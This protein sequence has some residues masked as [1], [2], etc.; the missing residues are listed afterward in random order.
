MRKLFIEISKQ[1]L[2]QDY[3]YL[4]LYDIFGAGKNMKEY[5]REILSIF[6]D[7]ESLHFGAYN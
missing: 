1:T 7:N 3:R 5:I 2:D 4:A 6:V